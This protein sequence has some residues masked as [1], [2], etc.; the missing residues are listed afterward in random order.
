M[1]RRKELKEMY[2]NLRPDMG[3]F[4]IKSKINDKCYIEGTQDLK[5]A[6]NSTKFKL[7]LG[8]HPNKELQKHWQE[9]GEPSFTIQ[10]LEE[11]KYD[12]D[13]TKIDYSEE[14]DILKLLWEDRLSSQGAEF[15]EK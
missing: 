3:L 4:I 8:N 7:G 11:L 2:K 9:Q 5:A 15:Y 1:D 14:L 6:L 10:I 13:E 12:E